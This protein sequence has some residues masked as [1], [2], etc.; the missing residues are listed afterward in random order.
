MTHHLLFFTQTYNDHASVVVHTVLHHHHRHHRRR[1]MMCRRHNLKILVWHTY[2]HRV[3]VRL[4]MMKILMI[5]QHHRVVSRTR[6]YW[7]TWMRMSC[8]G[9]C[10]M[11]SMSCDLLDRYLSN[12]SPDW[13]LQIEIIPPDLDLQIQIFSP[14]CVLQIQI[15][16]PELVLRLQIFPKI[17]LSRFKYFPQIWFSRFKYSPDCVLQIQI[18]ITQHTLYTSPKFSKSGVLSN[19]I[20]QN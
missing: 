19:K 7:M 4:V 10:V 14:D 1:N 8:D 11:V 13:F 20:Y 2:F 9:K 15:I 12:I 17:W 6:D 18:F 3:E 5:I 16:F